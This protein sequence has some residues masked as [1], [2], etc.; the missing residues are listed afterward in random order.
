MYSIQYCVANALI[1]KRCRLADFDEPQVREPKLAEIIEKVKVYADPTWD[2]TR[3]LASEVEVRMKDGRLV[4]R[5]VEYPRGT[6]ENP[7]SKEDL[8]DKF[9]DCVGYGGK[10]VSQS[11]A[12]ELYATVY[13][14]EDVSDV[15]G[16]I[17]LI[18][19]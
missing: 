14:M 3:Q 5:H 12:D 2:E 17:P 11:N 8:L 10:A 4:R 18:N 6:A 13:A 16:L 15:R 9:S 19:G 1:R 7:L